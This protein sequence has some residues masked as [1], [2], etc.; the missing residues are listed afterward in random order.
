MGQQPI[1]DPLQRRVGEDAVGHDDGGPA[2]SGL[3]KGPNPF[4]EKNLRLDAGTGLALA[5]AALGGAVAEFPTLGVLELGVRLAEKMTPFELFQV[6]LALLG[7]LDDRAER[8]IRQDDVE[9]PFRQ[10]HVLGGEP[11]E[12]VERVVADDVGVP[13]VVDDHVHLGDAGEFLIN[14][15]AEKVLLG[16]VVPIGEMLA[17]L[18]GVGAMPR[19]AASR[20]PAD[21]VER[22]EEEAARTTGGIENELAVFRIEHF[23]GKGNKLARCKVLSEVPLEEAAQ[24]LLKGDAFGVEF[25]TVERDAFEVFDALRQDRRVDVDA[26]GEN[27]RLAGLLGVI[28]AVNALGEVRGRLAVAALEGVGLAVLAVGILL[29]AVL[30]EDDFAE[31]AEG[32]DGLRRPPSQRV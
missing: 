25:G 18:P 28:E 2:G 11:G 27:V 5:L 10:P 16:E 21:V 15:D 13:V 8:G 9:P 31:L 24:E 20:F 22:V 4:E 19:E 17:R 12:E 26:V 30:D 23:D 32:G 3:K 7:A 6:A 1:A 29:V 14:L